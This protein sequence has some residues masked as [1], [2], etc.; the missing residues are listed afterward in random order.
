MNFDDILAAS[1][2]IMQCAS[3]DAYTQGMYVLMRH[4]F[5]LVWLY[6]LAIVCIGGFFVVNLFLAVLLEEF[7][8][9][10]QAPSRTSHLPGRAPPCPPPMPLLPFPLP[11]PVLARAVGLPFTRGARHT[12]LPTNSHTAC[13]RRPSHTQKVRSCRTAFRE[14]RPIGSQVEDQMIMARAEKKNT[15]SEDEEDGLPAIPGSPSEAAK[16]EAHSPPGSPR[17][18]DS[19]GAAAEMSELGKFVTSDGF[20]HASTALVVINLIV[21]CCPYAGMTTEYADNL[22]SIG[23]V[24]TVIFMAEMAL[25]LL[26]VGCAGYWR[27]SWNRLDGT[28]VIISGFDLGMTLAFAGGG[29][30]I[31]FLRILRMLRVLRML[32]LMRSW[33]GLYK[34]CMTLAK[35]IPQVG[36]V[37]VLFALI[38][39]IFALLGMQLFGGSFGSYVV[40]PSDDVLPRTHFD[41]IG[42][43]MLT[44][45]V[46]MSGSWFD[47]MM[48]QEAVTPGSSWFFV[49]VL[50]IGTYLLLNIFIT[51]LLEQFA[52]P[53]ED[54]G[55]DTEGAEAEDKAAE[56]APGE[57]PLEELDI[58]DRSMGLYRRDSCPRQFCTWVVASPKFDRLVFLLI[59]ASSICLAIDS[60]RLEPD[61][62]LA[63]YLTGLNRFFT[64]AFTCEMLLKMV[65]FGVC[66]GPGT[67][68]VSSEEVD[69]HGQPKVVRIP[70]Y[71]RD[72]WNVL[73]F[74]IVGVSWLCLLAEM[75]PALRPLKS[76]RILRVLRPLRLLARDPGMRLIITALV[77][78]MPSVT[79][80]FGVL[81]AVMMVFAILSLQL[82]SD[83]FGSCSDDSYTTR[84][85]CLAAAEA[86]RRLELGGGAEGPWLPPEPRGLAGLEGGVRRELKGG[87]DSNIGDTDFATSDSTMA[88]WLNPAFGS[89]DSFGSAM[90]LLYIMSTGD[91]WED[92]MF[93]GMDAVG[94]GVAPVRNDFSPS[95][96]FFIAWMF[97]GSFFALN[98]F[99]GTICDN[100]S[101]IKAETDGSATLTAGQAQWVESL[102]VRK[103]SKPS[104]MARP[105]N[106]KAR[107]LLFDVAMSRQF[108]LGIMGV[109]VANVLLMA[110]DHWNP[111][112][113]FATAYSRS[114]AVF[115]YIYYCEA[116]LKITALGLNYFRDNW[117]RFDFFLVCTTLLDQFGHEL[118]EAFLPMP[119][120]LLRVLRVLRILRVLRLLKDKRFKGL[121]DLL[122]TLVLSA[123]AL[124]NV[125]SLLGLLTFM[126]A[127]LGMQLFTYVIRGDM[128]TEDRNFESFGN[129]LLLLFQALTGD[130]WAAMMNACSASPVDT[131]CVAEQDGQPSSCGSRIAAVPFFVSFQF[132]GSFVFLNL[133]V[134]VILENF[135]SLGNV[136]PD[137]VS[138][139]DIATFKD[140]WA[141]FDP[142]ANS[143][144]AV[145]Q[146][147]VLLLTIP[148]PMG[149]K[150]DSPESKLKAKSRALSH[151]AKLGVPEHEGEVKFDEV[152]LALINFNFHKSEEQ[153]PN[154][155]ESP[156][157]VKRL[158]ETSPATTRNRRPSDMMRSAI[159]MVI[160][161]QIRKKM[162]ARQAA[163][164]GRRTPSPAPAL[165]SGPLCPTPSP[166]PAAAASAA[167]RDARRR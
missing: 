129:A 158:L 124:V 56:P 136:N 160:Q 116:V 44:I 166:A 122:M 89:F 154:L 33:K 128:L 101:R 144:I 58:N 62:S 6:Y 126:Y 93:Q 167:R 78:V 107:A 110:S 40:A 75:F 94:P 73:D 88:P 90:L 102:K 59:I 11:L 67:R 104:R 70:P 30:N 130:D 51:I 119:P 133:I 135:T 118:L 35:A 55:A 125:V 153:H 85:S 16:V 32:R 52:P 145:E 163:R 49:M 142:D 150:S 81:L 48:A 152:V 8:Q 60:P 141:A 46:I 50:A 149:L 131:E 14:P 87:H 54:E 97:F 120:M 47:I 98:L 112:E 156:D 10:K 80:V 28:I 72:L 12:P 20:G 146:L 64:A 115:S 22:E 2:V 53:E 15:L 27:D 151:C 68:V 38:T 123:P 82:F 147:P 162:A 100:F 164:Q 23:T 65:S 43:S 66:C 92:V 63:I 86:G 19:P 57:E 117:C 137:L 84:E 77:K 1:L 24:I 34:I 138:P 26:G 7:L 42:P 69:E 134:A 109:I 36:N 139:E 106:N 29:P 83:A 31:S 165:S 95:A 127:V 132:L 74:F 161:R 13:T 103:N 96:L 37:L 71:F 3:F 18:P 9:A 157:E 39:L 61:S 105:P 79:E 159:A 45:F 5:S 114:M 155:D 111:S 17:P 4:V 21:M 148:P 91:G 25:K 143:W 41:F 76:L 99:V 113:G 140:A 121:K 108:E